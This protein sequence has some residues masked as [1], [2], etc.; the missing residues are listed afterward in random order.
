MSPTRTIR[1]DN[2]AEEKTDVAADAPKKRRGVAG[3]LQIA[4][5]TTAVVLAIG[6]SRAESETPAAA[7][8]SASPSPAA[9]SPAAEPTLVRVMRPQSTESRVEV[10]TTGTVEVRSYV[11]LTPQIG[12]PVIAVSD[13]LKAGGSF[14][15]GEPLFT[16]DPRDYQLAL[17]QALADVAAAQSRLRLRQAEADAAMENY[18]LLHRDAPVPDLVAKVPQI[19]QS[20][21]DLAAARARAARAELDLSRT[22]F[23]LPFDGRITRSDIAVGQVLTKGQPAGQAFAIDA[24]EVAV[25]IDQTDLGRLLPVEGR[26]AEVHVNGR[27]YTAMLDRAAAELDPRTR[28][29][30][31]YLTLPEAADL[32]PGTFV[33]VTLYGE[34]IGNTFALPEASQQGAESVWVVAN[35]A[36]RQIRPSVIG[37]NDQGL[38]VDAF[39]FGEGIVVGTVPGAREGL[40]VTPVTPG[41]TVI[42]GH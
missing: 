14:Q 26:P 32:A 4:A 6:F 5:I 36:L 29:A 27:D 17:E 12:G 35:G 33:D 39:D 38:I 3:I 13:A 16:I 1:P 24:I 30:R 10:V 31:V 15:A 18:A 20:R 8:P 34:R 40:A 25:P 7:A 21:A 42:G 11:N 23:S 2:A 9:A 37:R 28:F 19:E 41:A 22:T